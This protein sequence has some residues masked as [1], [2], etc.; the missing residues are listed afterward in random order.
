[1]QFLPHILT[2]SVARLIFKCLIKWNKFSSSKSSM[3]RRYAICMEDSNVSG[4]DAFT[5]L[6]SAVE[7]DIEAPLQKVGTVS[8]EK[9]KASA[10]GIDAKIH[11]TKVW[12]LMRFPD[13][14]DWLLRRQ[15]DGLDKMDTSG[16]KEKVS[17]RFLSF[18]KF[19]S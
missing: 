18:L 11:Q 1:M 2:W 3:E 10:V 9:S 7:S 15:C 17:I 4:N 19:G 16:Y 8:K 12:C 6:Y 14:R 5:C 13:Y